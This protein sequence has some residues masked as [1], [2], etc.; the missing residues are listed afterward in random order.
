MTCPRCREGEFEPDG[1]TEHFEWEICPV[2]YLSKGRRKD[3]TPTP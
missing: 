3:D 2:C 1:E